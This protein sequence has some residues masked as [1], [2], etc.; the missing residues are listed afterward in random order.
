MPHLEA[1]VLVLK[2]TVVGLC[3][4]PDCLLNAVGFS[5]WGMDLVSYISGEYARGLVVLG[6]TECI[7]LFCPL[8]TLC[9]N[10]LA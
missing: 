3:S 10:I 8:G 5:S 7:R 2:N 4:Y 1:S 9:L 6:T